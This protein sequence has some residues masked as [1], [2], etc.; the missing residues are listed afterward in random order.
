MYVWLLRSRFRSRFLFPISS[1][2]FSLSVVVLKHFVDIVI[3][4]L[5]AFSRWT[6][7]TL[8]SRY[9]FRSF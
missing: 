2:S 3:L 1:L 6:T 5:L 9:F 4:I 8:Y 7:T